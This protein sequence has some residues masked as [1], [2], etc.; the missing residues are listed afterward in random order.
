MLQ[1]WIYPL[2]LALVLVVIGSLLLWR[3]R[4]IIGSLLV[5]IA[6]V[7]LYLLS[8]PAV[9][10]RLVASL[11]D[12]FGPGAVAEMPRADAIVVLGGGVIPAAPPRTRPDLTHM[13]DRLWYG[14]DLYR[15]GKA[16]LVITT[17]ARPYVDDGPSAADAAAD[18]LVRLGVPRGS[19]IVLPDSTST[20]EDAVAVRAELA[21]R[22]GVQALLLVTSALHMP[23][24]LTTFRA[25]GLQ[26]WPAPTDRLV[27]EPPVRDQWSWLPD[28]AAFARANRAW[29]EYV[30]MAYYRMR[31]WM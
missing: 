5:A 30:G 31:G 15:G 6:V 22:G 28:H 1:S 29:H 3:E 7:G 11:E 9:S 12:R 8:T 21:K 20:R 23:R 16:P 19:I 18:V 27:V 10:D 14:A 2:P 24:A 17:G 25:I 26:A 4:R 13:A